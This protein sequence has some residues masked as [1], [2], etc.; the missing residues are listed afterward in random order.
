MP[1]FVDPITKKPNKITQGE[2]ET[3][4][5][6]D[7]LLER[8]GDRREVF[9]L[10]TF[11]D[12]RMEECNSGNPANQR[13]KPAS[14]LVYNKV[15]G[16]VD[17]MDA[18]IRP[19]QALRKTTKWYRKYAFHLFDICI[20]SAFI[21]SCQFNQTIAKQGYKTYIL[22]LVEDII[23]SNPVQRSFLGRPPRQRKEKSSSQAHYPQSTRDANGKTKRSNCKLCTKNKIRNATK[24]TCDV[25]NVWLCNDG[26]NSCFVKYHQSTQ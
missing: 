8:W 21:L 12:H 19:Y 10:N 24:Y 11:I 2:V 14:V 1:R 3:F 22:S 26:E 9:M 17:N 5:D 20:Y 25:C 18:M 7:M 15:M 23:S 13:L 4:S 6:G 16:A